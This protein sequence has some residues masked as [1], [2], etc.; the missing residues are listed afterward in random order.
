MAHSFDFDEIRSQLEEYGQGHLLRYW[1]SLDDRQILHVTFGSVLNKPE[2]KRELLQI[3]DSFE[4]QYYDFLDVHFR[5][6]LEPF[7]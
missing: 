4:E 6:H 2:L 7:L 1:D 5:K 3:L